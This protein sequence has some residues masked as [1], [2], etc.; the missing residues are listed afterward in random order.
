MFALTFIRNASSARRLVRRDKTQD[1]SS[2][3]SR[4]TFTLTLAESI[5]SSSVKGHGE[6]TIGAFYVDSDG[7][8]FGKMET[9]D[10]YVKWAGD[11]HQLSLLTHEVD[12]YQNDLKKLQGKAVPRCYGFFTDSATDPKLGFL[13]LEKCSGTFPVDA[14]ELK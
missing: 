14:D 6:G 4:K 11:A 8:A 7:K 10:V 1:E 2:E 3:P 9:V 13:I 5:P 12:M